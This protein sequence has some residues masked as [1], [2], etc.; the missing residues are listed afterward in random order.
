ME[1][2]LGPWQFLVYAD[3][4]PPLYKAD[5]VPAFGHKVRYALLQIR[6]AYGG[7]DGDYWGG[8][9][10]EDRREVETENVE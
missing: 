10:A 1:G 2:P 4:S 3:G 5:D 6:L 9:V 8:D 7:L